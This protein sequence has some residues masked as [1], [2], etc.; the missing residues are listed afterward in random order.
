MLAPPPSQ[1][2]WVIACKERVDCRVGVVLPR[3]VMTIVLVFGDGDEGDGIALKCWSGL[4]RKGTSTE[5]KAPINLNRVH[6]CN[7]KPLNF[8]F[9]CPQKPF[10]S[11]FILHSEGYSS[12]F[13]LNISGTHS[14]VLHGW[15]WKI[16]DSN[17]PYWLLNPI[18]T[19]Y[20]LTASIDM[21]RWFLRRIE[22]V[23]SSLESK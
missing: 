14:S 16:F 17:N 10:D 13:S 5:R 12:W 8:H 22:Q 2:L 3:T 21:A 18:W 4:L 11:H 6:P 15:W 19:P 9:F 23:G 7:Q 20:I 1:P